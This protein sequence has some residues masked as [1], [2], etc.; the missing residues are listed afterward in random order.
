MY[1]L[2]S[3]KRDY[4]KREPIKQIIFKKPL[5][6]FLADLTELPY[7]IAEGTEFK[8]QLNII[9]HFSKYGFSYLLENK[10]ADKVY[11]VIEACLNKNGF[12][13]ELGTDNNTEFLN[14]KLKQFL[15]INDVKFI[16]GKS[17]HPRSQ[18]CVERLHRTFKIKLICEKLEYGDSFDIIKS[19]NMI[20]FNYNNS[21]HST[22]G[23]K[24]IEVFF[25]TSDNL[26]GEVFTNT[27]NFFK[28]VNTDHT[29]FQQFEKI[30][31]Y[32]NFIIDKS[33][34][35]LGLKYLVFNK[36]KKKHL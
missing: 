35:K 3:K 8:Y 18:G 17:F 23:Y 13:H 34:S 15:S 9:D 7:E 27:L 21:V 25:S 14:K 4:F 26:Y 30:L 16:H 12:P 6:R 20:L 10:T 5:E 24:P 32:S 11:G 22:T 1:C 31:L 2:F 33:K 28:Y 19:N 36:V 29:V